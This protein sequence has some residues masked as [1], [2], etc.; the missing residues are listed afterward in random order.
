MK[1][2]ILAGH[3]PAKPSILIP[4]VIIKK[5]YPYL[6]VAFNLQIKRYCFPQR[7]SFQR[8]AIFADIVAQF[9]MPILFGSPVQVEGPVLLFVVYA[10]WTNKRYFIYIF[11]TFV[12]KL[13]SYSTFFTSSPS[14]EAKIWPVLP[15]PSPSVS[16]PNPG[17]WA[18]GHQCCEEAK[19]RFN[20]PSYCP[21]LT[22]YLRR[23]RQQADSRYKMDLR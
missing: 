14:F 3:P 21:V 6:S 13:F 16:Q 22:P 7:S 11:V 1:D 8:K 5:P 15:F 4:G 10:I 12:K 9:S 2:S 17:S 20:T 18:S 19:K 23:S